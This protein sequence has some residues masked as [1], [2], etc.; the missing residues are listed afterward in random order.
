MSKKKPDFFSSGLFCFLIRIPKKKRPS[1]LIKCVDLFPDGSFKSYS[2]TRFTSV[3]MSL[4]SFIHS[5][6]FSC[7]HRVFSLSLSFFLSFL[8]YFFSNELG[9]EDHQRFNQQKSPK[10]SFWEMG[11]LEKCLP[12]D[13]DPR[14][15]RSRSCT[16]KTWTPRR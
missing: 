4:L 5:F 7:S 6:F 1:V 12:G 3:S 14:M 10:G 13:A 15:W 16:D 9:V 11:P 2:S 8:L